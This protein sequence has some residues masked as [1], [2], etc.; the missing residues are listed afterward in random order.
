MKLIFK[1]AKIQQLIYHIY[2]STQKENYRRKRLK[3]VR[4]RKSPSLK[5][6]TSKDHQNA[7][8][9]R[10]VSSKGNLGKERGQLTCQPKDGQ[11][12]QKT[13]TDAKQETKPIL[14]KAQKKKLQ[15]EYQKQF[16]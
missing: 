15:M 7:P 5:V 3:Q 8:I 1:L 16:I 14:T 13:V 11:N 2:N 12:E 4:K 6:T 9:D 10:K